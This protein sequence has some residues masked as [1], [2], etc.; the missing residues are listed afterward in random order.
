MQYSEKELKPLYDLWL[1]LPDLELNLRT[2]GGRRPI[3]LAREYGRKELAGR[4]EK[5]MHAETEDSYPLLVRE[6][7]SCDWSREGIFPYSILKKVL[8]DA[9][10]DLALAL[11]IFYLLDGYSFLS[12]CLHNSSSGNTSGKMCGKNAAEKWT[13]F[14][15]K[16]YTDILKGRYAKGPGAFKNPLTKVQKYK[17]RKLDTPDIFLED[18]P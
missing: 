14:M 7:D 10:C 5:K 1:S 4:L 16:L 13:A 18:I 12:S 6:V 2:F 11:K 3:D 17:L 15:E 9:L 8:K